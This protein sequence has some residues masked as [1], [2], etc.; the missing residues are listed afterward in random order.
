MH[1]FYKYRSRGIILRLSSFNAFMSFLLQTTTF[2]TIPNRFR[3]SRLYIEPYIKQGV[4]IFRTKGS[5]PS[6][7]EGNRSLGYDYGLL[8]GQ[9][10]DN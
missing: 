9:K 6:N 8:K 10:A 2:A 7:I 3:L 1:G 5:V 4:D